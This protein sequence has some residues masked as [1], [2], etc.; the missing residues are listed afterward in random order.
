MGHGL[1]AHVWHWVPCIN[2][3]AIE[4]WQPLEVVPVLYVLHCL[5]F[6]PWCLLMTALLARENTHRAY[7]T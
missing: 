1:A 2:R 3:L 5:T 7:D 6:T 4:I